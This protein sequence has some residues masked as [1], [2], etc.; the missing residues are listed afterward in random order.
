M[1]MATGLADLQG[2][3]RKVQWANRIRAEWLAHLDEIIALPVIPGDPWDASDQIGLI[4]ERE[5]E[6]QR[7]LAS[8]WIK[9]EADIRWQIQ[10]Y[11]EIRALNDAARGHV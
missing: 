1:T 2:Q 3:P 10:N 5:I 7:P 11:R 9:R 4:R 8:W 6:A